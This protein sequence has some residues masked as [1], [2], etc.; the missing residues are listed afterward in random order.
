[1]MKTICTTTN[2]DPQPV[3]LSKSEGVQTREIIK[4]NGYNA[5]CERLL[6][7]IRNRAQKEKEENG[8]GIFFH[9]INIKCRK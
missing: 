4:L 9:V 7:E 1:M 5:D 3:L 2:E 6:R 8:E